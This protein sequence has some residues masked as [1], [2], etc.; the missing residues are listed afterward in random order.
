M[1]DVKAK[2]LIHTYQVKDFDKGTLLLIKNKHI[3]TR[4]EAV[5]EII[6]E[7]SFPWP[8][9]GVFKIILLP[10]LDAMYKTVAKNRHR[11]FSKKSDCR[12]DR[13]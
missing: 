1:N 12:I 4:A 10:L 2:E 5:L 3:Y 9:L 13:Y 6:T 8:I 7:R 11:I